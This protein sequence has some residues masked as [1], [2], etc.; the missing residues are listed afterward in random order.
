[1]ELSPTFLL[2][3]NYPDQV[4]YKANND[5]II[6]KQSESPRRDKLLDAPRNKGSAKHQPLHK[7]FTAGPYPKPAK[8]S[9]KHLQ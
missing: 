2:I 9:T 1:M 3:L 6:Q 5:C 7:Y 4:R 8:V